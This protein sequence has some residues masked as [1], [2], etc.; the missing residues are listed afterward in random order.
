MPRPNSPFQRNDVDLPW[1]AFVVNLAILRFDYA[2]SP[3]MTLRIAVAVQ[4]VDTAVQHEHP[5][6][7]HLQARQ[8]LYVVYDDLQGNMPGRPELRNRQLVIKMTYLVSR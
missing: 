4:L 6:Q 7:L 8:R 5:L 3:R 2:L 1:G